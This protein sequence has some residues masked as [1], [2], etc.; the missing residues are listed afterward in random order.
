ML[1]I[2]D[3]ASKAYIA[4]CEAVQAAGDKVFNTV[5]LIGVDIVI[6]AYASPIISL[7]E[8]KNPSLRYILAENIWYAAGINDV[9]FISKFA[10]LWL[11]ITDDGKT[12]N[13]AYG[14]IMQN[15]FGF[16]QINK[17]I[18]I[19]KRNRYSRRAIIVIN[20]ANEN[21]E[22]TLD[23][24]CTMYLQFFIRNDELEMHTY[25]RSNDLIYGL[26]YDIPA[27]VYLQQYVH[28]LLNA[29]GIKCRLGYYY[30]HVSSLHY[31]LDDIFK[32][33]GI[34]K[35]KVSNTRADLNAVNLYS[36]AKDIYERLD[37][38][39]IIEECLREGILCWRPII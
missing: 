32:I 37:K 9:E 29:N 1:I 34:I 3:N 31:Y 33:N 12:S 28:Y 4:A 15:K 8:G 10:K 35:S 22:R 13:S 18:D 30:H 26:P 24:Q 36:K 21:V 6:P 11:N 20:D 5:E 39:N 23:E 25:M 38:N 14:F 2:K 19:F 7:S 16:N 27:F 17:L